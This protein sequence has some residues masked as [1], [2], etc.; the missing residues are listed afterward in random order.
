MEKRNFGAAIPPLKKALELKPDLLPA[1]QLLGY[2]LLAQGFAAEAVPHLQRTQERGAL[3]I[4]QIETGQLA[5]AVTNLQAALTKRP[6][7]PDL[8]YYLGRASGLLSKQ[9]ID[10]LV[11]AYPDS[12]RAH[13]AMA[14]NYFVLRQMPQAEH[15]YKAALQLRPDTPGLHLELGEV[16]AGA[17]QWE[18]AEE[19]FRAEAKLQPGN[20][21]ASYRLG[22]ALLQEGKVREARS[23]LTRAD[24]LQP[25][26]PETLYSL[27]KAASL[28]GDDAA[29]QKSWTAM[30]GVEKDTPLAGQAH[31][32]LANLY[33]KQGKTADAEREM[34]EFKRLQPEAAK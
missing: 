10:M 24:H 26:M 15:E 5:D 21:E 31:F 34:Q 4:A 3:G 32:A 33:R 18:K 28:D 27:G 8:L 17:A 2:A 29:A 11:G 23:S 6:G 9:T 12:A 19:E 30:L 20:A 16:Y 14:E 25:Q 1:H 13:Q 7:D 22:M